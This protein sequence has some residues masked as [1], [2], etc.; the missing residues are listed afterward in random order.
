MEYKIG[1]K[2]RALDCGYSRDKNIVDE[3]GIIFGVPDSG[4]S[5]YR[6]N[7][8]NKLANKNS[9]IWY[10]KAGEFKKACSIDYH[11]GI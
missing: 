1:D 11:Y 5:Y 6:I 9:K 8:L 4:C 3:I 10:M 7:T 2:I